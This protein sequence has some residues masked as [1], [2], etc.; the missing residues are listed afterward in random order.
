MKTVFLIVAL[1]IS[2]SGISQVYEEVSVSG[3]NH[4]VV[5]E[6]SGS[7]SLVT[8][9]KE[10]DALGIS[11]YVLC[12]REFADANSFFPANTYGLPNNGRFSGINR[13]YQLG[14]FSENN[15]LYLL[16]DESGTLTLDTAARFSNL[17]LLCM[18]TEGS[19]SISI[20]FNFSDGTAQTETKTILDWFNATSPFFGYGRV[21]RINGPFAAGAN[22]EGA[23]EGKPAFSIFDFVLPC[24]KTLQSITVLNSSPGFPGSGDNRVFI[25]AVSGTSVNITPHITISASQNNICKGDSVTFTSSIILGGTT[26]VYVWSINGSQVPLTNHP[27]FT[28]TNLSNGDVVTCSLSSNELCAFP[29]TVTS[30]PIV[31]VVNARKIPRVSIISSGAKV[32]QGTPVTYSATPINGGTPQY[33][34]FVNGILQSS[35]SSNFTLSDPKDGDEINCQMISNETCVAFDTA[36]S[37]IKTVAVTPVLTISISKPDSAN[38]EGDPITLVATPTGGDWFGLGVVG[39]QFFPNTAGLGFH[40]LYYSFPGNMCTPPD[41]TKIKVFAVKLPCEYE[42]AELIT[43]NG[44]GKNDQWKVGIFNKVCIQKAEVEIFNRWGKSIYKNSTYDNQWDGKIDGKDL[45]SG[46]YFFR[47][48]YALATQSEPIIKVGMLTISR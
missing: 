16:R 17:S 4:D 12:T 35:D 6:G 28:Q 45:N 31:M 46:V 42:P 8:T 20:T 11:N 26:P 40:Y 34:W 14:S 10:M 2:F 21:K 5:A 48:S 19:A 23:P 27:T 7:S 25:F 30:T 13:S 15:V 3:F 1:L 37:N 29:A 43:P 41:S 39:N 44:D 9:T 18:A 38:I 22:Y 36:S 24:S 32:C 33:H 47:I